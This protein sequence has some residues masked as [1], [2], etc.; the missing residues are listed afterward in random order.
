M[1]LAY[2]S[3]IIWKMGQP[4]GEHCGGSIAE[5]KLA[6]AW[7]CKAGEIC[8]SWQTQWQL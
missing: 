5:N 7:F 1:K 6:N 3:W 4:Q 8:S 2:E